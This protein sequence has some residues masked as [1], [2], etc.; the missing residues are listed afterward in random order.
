VVF[1]PITATGTPVIGDRPTVTVGPG[2]DGFPGSVW[3]TYWTMGGI[4]VSGAGVSGC[5]QVG[6]FRSF[7]PSQPAGVNFG[8][9]A[10]GPGGEVMVTYGPNGFSGGSVYVNTKPDALGPGAFASYIAVVPVNMGGFTAIPAQPNW[11]VGPEPGLAWDR[12]AGPYRGRAYLVYTDA[13]AGTADTD[14]FV[15][16][17]T[18]RARVGASRFA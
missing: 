10:V 16:H 5:G 14:I 11:G 2:T 12:S 9:I 8:S 1:L 3:I 17:P 6:P 18:I 4:A 13:A 7:Q 15:V